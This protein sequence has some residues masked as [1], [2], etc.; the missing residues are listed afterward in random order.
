MVRVVLGA[1]V[2]ALGIGSARV[3]VSSAE[4]DEQSAAP[5]VSVVPTTVELP[6]NLGSVAGW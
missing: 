4:V 5:T 3:V 1:V 6:E 2:L